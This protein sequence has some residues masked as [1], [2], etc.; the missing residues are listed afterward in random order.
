MSLRSGGYSREFVACF[1][2]APEMTPGLVL[3]PPMACSYRDAPSPMGAP[4]GRPVPA[5]ARPAPEAVACPP[6]TDRYR[7]GPALPASIAGRSPD[8]RAKESCRYLPQVVCGEDPERS[9]IT[10][11]FTRRDSRP[12]S[13][14]ADRIRGQPDGAH[15]VRIPTRTR[16]G[17]V[18]GQR[19]RSSPSAPH[20]ARTNCYWPAGTDLRRGRGRCASRSRSPGLSER[21][22]DD[23]QPPLLLVVGKGQ[24]RL[25]AFEAS[26][27]RTCLDGRHEP[28]NR[29]RRHCCVAWGQADAADAPGRSDGEDEF[30]ERGRY[31]AACPNFRPEFVVA[32]PQVLHE[33]VPSGDDPQ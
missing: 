8:G 29:P 15:G 1:I 19:P 7:R 27:S 18:V 23:L 13:H 10:D 22:G 4:S 14:R 24:G 32:A 16:R 9:P 12:H 31:P 28:A 33:G 21:G 26:P 2:S 3:S 5:S 17:P 6:R 11:Y 25:A 20:P 30:G